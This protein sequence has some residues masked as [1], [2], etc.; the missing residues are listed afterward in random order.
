MSWVHFS[1]TQKVLT[2]W[3][4]KIQNTQYK[5]EQRYEYTMHQEPIQI[6]NTL[7]KK[8]VD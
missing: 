8:E 3:Q 5:N 2:N 1:N 4:E 6:T 7:G